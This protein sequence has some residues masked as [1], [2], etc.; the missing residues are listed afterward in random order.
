MVF[1]MQVVPW[2]DHNT[3]KWTF[4]EN[5]DYTIRSTEYSGPEGAQ[6]ILDNAIHVIGCEK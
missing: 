2:N 6:M 3:I 1:P 4:P 5:G